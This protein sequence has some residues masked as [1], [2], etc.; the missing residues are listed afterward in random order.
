MTEA[1]AATRSVIENG[2]FM[3]DVTA[4]AGTLVGDRGLAFHAGAAV[5]LLQPFSASRSLVFVLSETELKLSVVP[6][7]FEPGAIFQSV[8]LGSNF[9]QKDHLRLDNLFKCLTSIF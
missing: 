3:G 8:F 5:I 1:C 6:G 9:E 7:V 2:S 4:R